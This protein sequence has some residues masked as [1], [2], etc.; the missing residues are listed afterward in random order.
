MALPVPRPNRLEPRRRRIGKQARRGKQAWRCIGKHASVYT[1]VGFNPAKYSQVSE[2]LAGFLYLA[3]RSNPE[4]LAGFQYPAR[5]FRI[6]RRISISGK[7][8]PNTSP[9]FNI[10]RGF[11]EYLDGFQYP[12]R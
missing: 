5:Y 2:Y 8:I 12:A 7:V 1:S 6:P 3:R 11:S 4:Y 10:Q 9:D